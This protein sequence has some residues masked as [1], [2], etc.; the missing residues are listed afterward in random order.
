[1]RDPLRHRALRPGVRSLRVRCLPVGAGGQQ[2]RVTVVTNTADDIWLHGLKVCPDLDTVMYTLGGGI[3]EEQGW[4]RAQET[5]NVLPELAA[6]GAGPGWFSLG[7]RDFATHIAR[8]AMLRAGLP[9]SRAVAMH[10]TQSDMVFGVGPAGTGKTYLAVAQAVELSDEKYCTV[11]T[12]T[13]P[14]DSHR[15]WPCTPSARTPSARAPSVCSLLAKVTTWLWCTSV[16][17][18]DALAVGPEIEYALFEKIGRPRLAAAGEALF[19]RGDLGT[20]MFVI[21]QGSVDLDFGDDLVAGG[22]Q[23]A[24]AAED[25]VDAPRR[26]PHRERIGVAPRP[27]VAEP[28]AGDAE[29]LKVIRRLVANTENVGRAF[30]EEARKIHYEEAPSRGIRGQ[31]TPEEAEKLRI[32]PGTQCLTARRVLRGDG[33]SGLAL[34]RERDGDALQ[35]GE[36][37]EH[38]SGAR[39][40]AAGQAAGGRDP[41]DD[42]LVAAGPDVARGIAAAPIAIVDFAPTASMTRS[43]LPLPSVSPSTNW[44]TR[45][46][47]PSA[48]RRSWWAM[49]RPTTPRASFTRTAS[50]SS[51][52]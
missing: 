15:P 34:L 26:L 40:L 5:F 35:L 6:Y 18:P 14:S 42:R 45:W 20:T 3:H 8:T 22:L 24:A 27:G 2:P 16:S 10:V 21:A 38:G 52:S 17:A 41:I 1:M 46:T 49:G 31:A 51:S 11:I 23:P 48:P 36:A 28:V 19:R 4:G 30:A 39:E 50:T 29:A 33:E 47:F 32:E 37:G 44:S 13:R 12:P 9:L 25:V 7:D 43:A